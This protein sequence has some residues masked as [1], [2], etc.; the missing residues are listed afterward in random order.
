MILNEPP[1]LQE[2]ERRMEPGVIT[3]KGFLGSDGRSLSDILDADEA[4]V[5]SR[6]LSHR[7][8]AS[9]L[10]ELTKAGRHG[11]GTEVDVEERYRIWVREW[12]GGMPCPWGHRGLYRKSITHLAD[13][14][15][16]KEMEWT[17][18]SV[19]LIREH[20]FYGGKGNPYRVEPETVSEVLLP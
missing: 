7:R 13:S 11:L 14:E 17:A 1:D 9:R 5:H 10:D 2:V 19:H 16:G 18:L 15:T 8:I 4:A 20:G 6:G 3:R 12:R